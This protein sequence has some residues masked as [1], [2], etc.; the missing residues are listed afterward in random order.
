M[1]IAVISDIHANREAFAAVL[2]DLGRMGVD[3]TVCLGDAI[4]YGPEPETV[5]GMLRAGAIPSVIGNHDLAAI[6]PH[7]LH[8]FN[9]PARVS[10]KQS[11][12]ALS[13]PSIEYIRGF[14]RYM[15]RHGSRFVHGF[16][17]ASPI[18]YQFAVQAKRIT[19]VFR[20]AVEPVC[21]TGHTHELEIITWDGVTWARAPLEQGV[22]FLETD[23][24]YI[25]NIGSVG[26]PR[27]GN[28]TAKYVIWMPDSHR[29]ELRFVPY[30]VESVIKKILAAG[31]PAAHAY[32][33]R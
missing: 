6:E 14:S 13:Q 25:V 4:G 22:T 15:V 17:P 32:R 16:P 30:D 8:W 24:K 31:L 21:F 7:Y 12:A 5:V 28:N 10:L 20:Q 23:K 26:Q 2:E 27:D 29:L 9:T 19:S 11:I 18:L 33:L 1:R 3:E